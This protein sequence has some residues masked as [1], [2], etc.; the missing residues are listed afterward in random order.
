MNTIAVIGLGF[1]GLTTALGFCEKSDFTVYGIENDI[2]RK[3]SLQNNSL[4]F[5]E[6]G[7]DEALVEYNKSRFIL[8]ET[9]QN[10][11]LKSNIIF[12]CVGTPCDDTGRADLS[13]VKQ[14]TEE[15]LT[16]KKGQSP[17]TIA[18]KSTVPPT[19]TSEFVASICNEN[20]Y[21]IGKDVFLCSNPE[22]LR[23]GKA[24][25]DFIKPDRIVIGGVTE[26]CHKDLEELYAEFNAPI[27]IVNSNTA[28]FTKYASNTLLATLISY[29]N[30]MSMIADYIGEIDVKKAFDT[31]HTDKRWGTPT[32]NMASYA[33]PG[34]GFGGY[35]LPK[36]TLALVSKAQEKGYQANILKNVLKVNKDIKN[37]FVEKIMRV[38]TDNKVGILGLSF[39]SESDD[40]RNTPTEYIIRELIERGIQIHAYDPMGND[41]FKSLYGM[42]IIFEQNAKSLLVSTKTVAILTGWNEFKTLDYRNNIVVDGRYIL[43]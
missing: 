32:V 25:E 9:A 7:L 6:P 11:V 34:C 31:L 16:Y 4:P 13:Y 17:F 10:A 14:A 19:T 5:Y 26:N 22:F 29:S 37:H 39:K 27:I 15:I 21:E 1:V 12:I 3:S 23:E 30:E 41:A 2:Q 43:K 33:Y 40:V 18:I 36:D 20:N 24:W 35:C 28:E 8:S 42:P 38:V